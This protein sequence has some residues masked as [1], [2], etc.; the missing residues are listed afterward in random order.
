[1]HGINSTSAFTYKTQLYLS[2]VPAV[3]IRWFVRTLESEGSRSTIVHGSFR[4]DQANLAF[5]KELRG[6][7]S[8]QGNFAGDLARITVTGTADVAN[9]A[10]AGASHARHLSAGYNVGVDAL[11]GRCPEQHYGIVCS[12]QPV[13]QR[14]HYK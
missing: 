14:F 5:F 11:Q 1:M 12:K 2:E 7:L 4:Y 9:F 10:L 13:V 8:A 3:S 6:M